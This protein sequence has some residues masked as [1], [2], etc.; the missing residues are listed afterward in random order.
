[1]TFEFDFDDEIDGPVFYAIRDTNGYSN[2]STSDNDT[3]F[4]QIVSDAA[5][6]APEATAAPLATANSNIIWSD[7]SNNGGAGQ[8]LNGFELIVPSTAA[9]I[10]E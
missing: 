7:R 6:A 4:G 8:F 1:M 2:D 10:E 5:A 3:I 9:G